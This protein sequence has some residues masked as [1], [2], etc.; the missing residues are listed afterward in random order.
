M[1]TR[2]ALLSLV[3]ILGTAWSAGPASAEIQRFTVEA[4][5]SRVGF[6]A[7]HPIANFSVSSEAPTG[8][9]EADITDLKQP[10][11]GQF[12]VSAASLRSGDKKRDRDLFRVLDAEHQPEIRYRIEK[13]ESSFSSLAENTD[14]LLT[15]HGVL[16]MKGADRPVAFA[17][18]VR[19]RPGGALWV[20][21]ESWIKPRDWGVPPIRIWLM[22]VK[23][24]VLATFDLVLNKAQ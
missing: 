6:D 18:R 16:T 20:R 13:V 7:F 15:I 21:G 5:K 22:S 2:P 8:E 12:S 4:G 9:L 11:K 24:N 19:L 17:G 1:P 23:E 3:W 14:V 10:V